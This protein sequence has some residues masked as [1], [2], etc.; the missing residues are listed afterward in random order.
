MKQ[1][2]TKILII[3]SVFVMLGGSAQ[4]QMGRSP[5]DDVVFAIKS[6]RIQ[7][8]SRYFDNFVPISINN[9]QSNY[10]RNQAELVLRDFFEKNPARNFS[11]MDSGSPNATSRF[12]IGSFHTT[13]GRYSIYILMKMKDNS[14]VVKEIRINRE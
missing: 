5:V 8:M 1:L 3:C 7:D 11:V 9:T 12:M 13:N 4:A 6:N 2:L 10:S 14:F